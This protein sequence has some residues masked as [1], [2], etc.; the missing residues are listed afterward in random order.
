MECLCDL[1]IE[2]YYLNKIETP[3]NSSEKT[4]E[5]YYVNNI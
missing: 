4:H 2:K 3:N 5:F 1:G